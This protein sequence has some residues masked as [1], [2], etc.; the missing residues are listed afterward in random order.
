MFISVGIVVLYLLP[1]TTSIGLSPVLLTIPGWIIALCIITGVASFLAYI[2]ITGRYLFSTALGIF[3]L[4]SITIGALTYTTGGSTSPFVGLW[5]VLTVFSGMFGFW[6][7]GPMAISLLGYLGYLFYTSE[8]IT[9]TEIVLFFCIGIM[10]L[11][12]SFIIWHRQKRELTTA[13][14]Q[15]NTAPI[16][17]SD[18]ADAVIRAI[19]N[20]VI[21]INSKGNID[22]IN[23]AAQQILGWKTADA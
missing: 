20:G 21:S 2:W 17:S 1:F 5:V 3:L 8:Q 12:A 16:D 14:G 10:P 19:D 9:P 6:G 7:L 11:T 15:N 22:L 18:K 13:A 4:L 23:P